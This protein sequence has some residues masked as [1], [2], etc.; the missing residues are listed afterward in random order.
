MLPLAVVVA[1]PTAA[2]AEVDLVHAAATV[3]QARLPDQADPYALDQAAIRGMMR[4]LDLQTGVPGNNDLLTE[5]Q[6]LARRARLSGERVGLGIEFAVAPGR[7]LVIS[8]VFEGSPAAAAGVASGDLVVALNDQP[9]TGLSGAVIQS[10]VDTLG[11]RSDAAPI[12]LDLRDAAGKL[13][14]RALQPAAFLVPAARVTSDDDHVL[15][16][17]DVIGPGAVDGVSQALLGT[18]KRPVVMDLRDVSVG[19]VADLAAVAGLFVEEGQPVLR[20]VDPAGRVD[21]SQAV[22]AGSAGAYHGPL[23]VL[24]NGGTSGLGE[25]LA[26]ALHEQAG[27]PLVGTPTAGVASFPS[28]HPIGDGLVLQLGDTALL[29]GA[30]ATWSRSGLAVDLVVQPVQIPL[31]G[32]VRGGLPDMQLEAALRYLG[33]P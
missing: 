4:W 32:P 12:V 10:L 22:S 21:T 33:T 15:V 11:A 5:D 16:R 30:G 23:V 3:I 7:G 14:R 2:A 24:V 8:T 31:L 17:L 26:A 13:H 27:A 9:L 20:A 18:G 19:T 28:F 1:V 29:T 25:A 6:L